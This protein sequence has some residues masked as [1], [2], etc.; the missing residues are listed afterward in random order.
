MRTEIINWLNTIVYTDTDGD[1][2]TRIELIKSAALFLMFA[3][4]IGII[5]HFAH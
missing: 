2:Y 4:G 1:T 5:G 3:V